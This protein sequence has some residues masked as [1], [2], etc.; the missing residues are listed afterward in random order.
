METNKRRNCYTPTVSRLRTCRVTIVEENGCRHTTEV[1][2][3]S[4]YE[5][6][7]LGLRAFRQYPWGKA[8]LRRA[9]ARIEVVVCGPTE[10]HDV[11]VGQVETWLQ[12]PARSPKERLLKD[13]LQQ[14]GD[15]HR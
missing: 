11:T 8:A 9:E 2:A 6:A 12:T 14:A 3:A 1:T 15:D 5:A 4:L 13:R 10:A 7:A